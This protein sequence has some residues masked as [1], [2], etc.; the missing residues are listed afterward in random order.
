MFLKRGVVISSAKTQLNW[1]CKRTMRLVAN[2]KIELFYY[3]P[4]KL[5]NHEIK[6]LHVLT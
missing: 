4:Y 5:L 6:K 3:K 1:L 2:G